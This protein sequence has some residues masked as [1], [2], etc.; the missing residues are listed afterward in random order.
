[1]SGKRIGYIRV[2]M[3]SQNPDRQ[4]E[5]VALDKRFI[6]HA[7][8][9]SIDRPQLQLLLDYI[10]EDDCVLVHSMDRLARNVKDLKTIVDTLVNQGVQV[11]FVKEGLIFNRESN[12]ISNL[13]LHLMGA[14]A[15]FEHAFI[16][17]RQREGIEIAKKLGKFKGGTKKITGEKM[18]Y[19]I[20]QLPTRKSKSLI[21]KELGVSRFT[22]YKYI[23]EIQKK[24]KALI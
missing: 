3:P 7:S 6:E 22:L 2:S 19:L 16:L 9:K 5:G 1:M 4:L 18:Q 11:H 10:R 21:A 14:F 17:E 12:A 13:M 15:E 24:E 20:S 8:A 23:R